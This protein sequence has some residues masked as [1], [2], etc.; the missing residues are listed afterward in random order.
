[1]SRKL[2]AKIRRWK[3]RSHL[4]FPIYGPCAY[5]NVG[6]GPSAEQTKK[7][8]RSELGKSLTGKPHRATKQLWSKAK[9]KFTVSARLKNLHFRFWS[10]VFIWEADHIKLGGFT[11]A[12]SRPPRNWTWIRTLGGPALFVILLY[13]FHQ[14][15]MFPVFPN[16]LL[17]ISPEAQLP[18]SLFASQTYNWG[19]LKIWVMPPI[20][21][22]ESLRNKWDTWRLLSTHIKLA[23]ISNRSPEFLCATSLDIGNASARENTALWQ[24]EQRLWTA[25]TH[26]TRWGGRKK[27]M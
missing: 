8:R 6:L 27:C 26:E 21:H 19:F 17:L 14:T 18:I 11:Q 7:K 24:S 4:F 12:N 22:F 3:W 23:W 2:A 10:V 16:F 20:H 5:L 25:S 15:T 13:I 9:E 1:M